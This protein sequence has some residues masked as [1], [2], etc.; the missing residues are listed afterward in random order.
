[1]EPN[2]SSTVTFINGAAQADV[3]ILPD[4]QGNRKTT[5]WGAATLPGVKTGEGVPAAPGAPGDG[6]RY[7][8]RMID[9]DGFYYSADGLALAPGCTVR[10]KETELMTYCVEVRDAAGAVIGDYSVFA[11]RL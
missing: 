2:N 8:L 9:V 1:M 6:G 11:A 4:T 3:W 10:L 7:L 5:L